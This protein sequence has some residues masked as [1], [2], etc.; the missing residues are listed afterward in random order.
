MRGYRA[1]ERLGSGFSGRSGGKK[2]GPGVCSSA[3][4]PNAS[5]S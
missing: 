5:L 2:T 3:T 4:D 1:E